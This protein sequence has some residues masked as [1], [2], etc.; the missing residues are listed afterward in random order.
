MVVVGDS[1]VP[2]VTDDV[3]NLGILRLKR[4]MALNKTGTINFL[5][6]VRIHVNVRCDAV[7]ILERALIPRE[8]IADQEPHP[9]VAGLRV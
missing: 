9:R 1:Y 7:A 3:D 6:A 8:V 4:G 2:S 5:T